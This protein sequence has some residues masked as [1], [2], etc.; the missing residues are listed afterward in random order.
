MTESEKQ[1]AE[2]AVKSA[3]QNAAALAR[4]A[5]Q[6]NGGIER[7][8]EAVCT[9]RASWR[10]ILQEFM[11]ERAM[12]DYDFAT[13]DKRLLHQYGVF[14]PTISGHTLGKL[15]II[16]DASGS[17]LQDQEQFCSE[18]SDILANYQ[19]DITLIHH[20][21]KVTGVEELTQDDLPLQIRPSG[22]GG[23]CAQSA[24]KYVHD[25][26][27][28]DVIIHTTDMEM[29]WNI[30]H[31]PNCPVLIANS[32]RRYAEKGPAWAR[33]IDISHAR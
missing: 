25:N 17:C 23:T 12:V 14:S 32:N 9:P 28:P 21:T 3:I 31:I 8:V 26:L 20:D 13:I 11:S 24:Y 33:V 29:D 27:D 22:F 7:L 5:G 30:K 15:V 1:A 6:M 18:L 4:K 2:A 19:V 10:T 16:N